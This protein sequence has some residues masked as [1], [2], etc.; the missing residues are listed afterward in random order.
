MSA[1]NELDDLV[2]EALFFGVSAARV[3]SRARWCAVLLLL[4]CVVPFDVVGRTPIFLWTI[5]SE[6][7]LSALLGALALP[8]AGALI[9]LGS[10]VAKRGGSLGF[11]VLA[12]LLCAV[13]L[14]AFGLERAAWDASS[15][16]DSLAAKPAFAL[17]S[18][19]LVAA[20]G[21]LSFR[22]AT[23]KVVPYALGA[24]ALS[25]A[26]FYAYPERG[27]APLMTVV[28]GL[29]SLPDLPDFRF[30]LGTIILV[31]IALWPL[32]I[33]LA[34]F[35]LLKLPAGKDE[36]AI[37][38]L[39]TWGLPLL[40]AFLG[41]RALGVPEAGFGLLLHTA[42]VLSVTAVSGLL[43]SA[44]LVCCETFFVKTGDDAPASR[45]MPTSIEEEADVFGKRQSAATPRAAVG[46]APTR[47]AAS[48]G[49]AVLVITI[50]GFVL[51]RPPQKGTE[52]ELKPATAAS[53]KVF[54]ELIVSWMIARR[55]WDFS[56]RNDAG[57]AQ[58]R[59]LVKERGK[60]LS[61]AAKE[62]D[63]ALGE[64]VRA[65]TEE[66]DDL[67]LGGR[68]WGR[69]VEGVN[70][71]S[72]KAGLPYFLDPDVVTRIEKDDLRQSFAVFPYR[73]EQVQQFDVD[74]RAFATLR[75]H[76][77]G[78]SRQAHGR[79]GYSRDSLPF[80]LVILE[81]TEQQGEV[82]ASLVRMGYCTDDI[83]F[84]QELYGGLD[85]C[86]KL[87]KD[88]AGSDPTR[89]SKAVLEGTERHELQ[90][91]IDGPHLPT[92][93]IVIE[94][95]G[96]YAKSSQDRVN[97][98]VSAFLA[99]AT[100]AGAAPKVALVQLAQ[101]MLARDDNN[102][103][104]SKTAVACFEALSKKKIRRGNRLDGDAFWK[105]YEELFLLSDDELRQRAR[106]AWSEQFDAELVEPK[107]R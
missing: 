53:D 5:A 21:N 65:M 8:L 69:L 61:Q 16:P 89:V 2:P 26:I 90:H 71:A 73:I 98:E 27:E 66:S 24:A 28:R 82:F 56:T 35:F 9:G 23:K 30:Q 12:S 94:T 70:E 54:D 59:L 7:H 85:R 29:A 4:T 60:K 49:G 76:R 20:A 39:A 75:V 55:N 32:L 1:E 103:T 6:L 10:F 95:M 13:I 19:A 41:V 101:Y 51:S 74:G 77:I 68:K 15:L 47:A 46:L 99:E 72:R 14:R 17:V 81:E 107:P 34:S 104:Y 57:G 48:A 22:A 50:A 83:A 100:A 52:W 67:D 93:P 44:L 79:L 88:Y 3:R 84:N 105:V 31:F 40:L 64:A 25:A 86:G 106:L 38:L 97:R 91:Q 37:S 78:N 11:L 92:A 96:G 102:G 42:M 62:L 18:L 45:R 33:C 63:S 87:F 43:S 36:P 80:A 58:D